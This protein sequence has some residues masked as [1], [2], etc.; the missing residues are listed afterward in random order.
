MHKLILIVWGRKK[1]IHLECY[2]LAFSV[3][4]KH[5]K[6]K[7]PGATGVTVISNMLACWRFHRSVN[8]A[9]AGED[10]KLQS[11]D[12]LNTQQRWTRLVAM[13]MQ[14]IKPHPALA[15]VAQFE[16]HMEILVGGGH[17]GAT[18]GQ[19]RSEFMGR[20]ASCNK[21]M[22]KALLLQRDLVKWCNLM[23][24]ITSGRVLFPSHYQMLQHEQH[25][26]FMW[27]QNSIMVC[28]R[29]KYLFWSLR[30]KNPPHPTQ[31]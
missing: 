28:E 27:S 3:R 13:V 23:S 19:R 18:A 2:Y 22:S 6:A 5:C 12:P 9:V 29:E 8:K 10:M 17:V 15:G 14:L 7:Q 21:N 30:V 16:M 31:K 4:F 11:W 25:W 20:L 1:K 26:H 24:C